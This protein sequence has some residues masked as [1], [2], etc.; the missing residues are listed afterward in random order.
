[1][2]RRH[3][4]ISSTSYSTTVS[5][6]NPHISQ[7]VLGPWFSNVQYAQLQLDVLLPTALEEEVEVED[8]DALEG[9]ERERDIQFEC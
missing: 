8:E 1:M 7:L 4:N 2:T 9:P 5:F 3:A 6:G